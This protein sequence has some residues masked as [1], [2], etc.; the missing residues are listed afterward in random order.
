MVLD[1][2]N[3]SS[4]DVV[5]GTSWFGYVRTAVAVTSEWLKDL[6]ETHVLTI[7]AAGF[8]YPEEMAAKP[9]VASI[10]TV[11][12]D[13]S[14]KWIAEKYFLQKKLDAKIRFIPQSAR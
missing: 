9:Y 13:P 1:E 11:D 3:A 8:T 7:G 4:I 10:D 6:K 2:G 12:V 5:S 14:V